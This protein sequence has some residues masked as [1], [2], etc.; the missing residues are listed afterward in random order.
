MKLTKFATKYLIW[1]LLLILMLVAC[2]GNDD[3][4]N[5]EDDS[6]TTETNTPVAT[7]TLSTTE[8]ES[9]TLDPAQRTILEG[10]YELLRQSQAQIEGIWT[11]LRIGNEVS[12]ATELQFPLSPDDITSSD[13]VSVALFDAAVELETAYGMWQAECDNNRSQPPAD[14]ID[15][16]VRAALAAGDKLD[17]AEDLLSQ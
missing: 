15:G 8:I 16:G 11:D 10:Q 4:P 5:N 17:D 13:P 3:D 12:C 14:V 6:R 2:G 7:E 9:P 1:G